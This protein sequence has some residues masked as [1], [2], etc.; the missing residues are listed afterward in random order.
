MSVTVMVTLPLLMPL[1]QYTPNVVLGAIIVSAVVGLIDI[2]AAY[3]IWK[4]DKFDFIVLLCAF[5]G[6]IFI[7][8]Q[9]GLAFAVC[10]SLCNF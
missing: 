6:V 3:Q 10:I 2:P 8:V 4:V 5:L 9:D 7:S 1:F